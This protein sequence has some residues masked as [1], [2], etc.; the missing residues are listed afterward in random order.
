MMWRTQV[1]LPH[2]LR[3]RVAEYGRATGQ[4]Q[5]EIVRQ[6]LT[7]LLDGSQAR[8]AFTAGAKTKGAAHD[9]VL[10]LLV[11]APFD[12]PHPDP[13]LARDAD[14]HLYGAPRRSR[15]RAR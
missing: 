10:S 12:D 9:E 6:A 8:E 14:H 11:D 13:H 7:Q 5:G 4:S 15:K 2:A 3:E 1:L